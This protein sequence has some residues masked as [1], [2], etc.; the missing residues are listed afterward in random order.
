M[1]CHH[2]IGVW[3]PVV[4]AESEGRCGRIRASALCASAPTS[5]SICRFLALRQRWRHAERLGFD[6]LW[7][8]DAILEPDRARHIMFDGPTMLTLMGA[9]TTSIRVGSL[10][11]SLYFR[12]PVTLTKATMTIDHLSGGRVELALGVGDPSAGAQ[13]AVAWTG[14]QG[15]G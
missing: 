3:R 12:H 2:A 1:Q 8:C 6:V 11:T 10:V 4:E 14:R 15:N 9:E 7:N 5:T 13:A